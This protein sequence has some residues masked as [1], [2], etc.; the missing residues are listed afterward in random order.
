[1]NKTT[2]IYHSADFD[3]LFCREIARRF[4]P[5]DTEFIGWNFKD[6]PLTVPSEGTI[7][8]MDLPVDRVFGFNFDDIPS[9]PYWVPI[10]KRLVWI[11]HHASSIES[12]P[13]SISGYRIDGVA[14]CRLAWQWFTGAFHNGENL[15]DLIHLLPEKEDYTFR[16]VSE[17]LAVRLAGEYDIHDPRMKTEPEIELFQHGLRSQEL[18]S[19]DWSMLLGSEAY[20]G[21][22]RGDLLDSLLQNARILQFARDREYRDVITS[23]GF[24]AEFEGVKF[25]ACN[26]HECDIRSQL[27]EAGIQPY[28]EALLGFTFTGMDY[29]VSMYWIDGRETQPDILAIAKKFNGG[30]HP[31][32]CGFHTT[33]LPF[34]P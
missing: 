5:P 25:L 8:V 17:P 27:F 21:G 15:K 26:S 34:L 18:T 24:N 4:L 11:D 23:Q 7:Y 33:K 10:E 12:H 31:G 13:A 30:G 3:G 29:R 1:M 2:V 28:H 6:A 32:A 22:Q 14:A 16:T 19:T 9:I 20:T